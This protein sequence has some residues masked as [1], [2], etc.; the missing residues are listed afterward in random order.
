MLLAPFAYYGRLT[1]GGLKPS[2]LK[3]DRLTPAKV[4]LE[5]RMPSGLFSNVM[6]CT[7][8]VGMPMAPAMPAAL[9][10]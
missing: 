3:N 6:A 2:S 5:V 8:S 10:R 1:A 4:W 9:M 7:L